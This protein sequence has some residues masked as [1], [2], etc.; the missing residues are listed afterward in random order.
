MW[1]PFS[2][3]ELSM[4]PFVALAALTIGGTVACSVQSPTAP[5]AAMLTSPKA[6]S[7]TGRDDPLDISGYWVTSSFFYA[8]FLPGTGPDNTWPTN[9]VLCRSYAIIENEQWNFLVLKHDGTRILGT[10]APG[11]GIRCEASTPGDGPF[12]WYV[13]ID[14]EFEGRVEGDQVRLLLNKHIEVRVKPA[15]ND[16][17]AWLGTIRV[18]MDPRPVAEPYWIEQGFSLSSTAPYPCWWYQLEPPNCID[19]AP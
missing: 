16:D 14:D 11:M 19:V 7:A 4:R 17:N 2:C 3:R 5:T 9:A 18:R 10:S 13:D 8:D 12:N 15:P 1:A 6:V